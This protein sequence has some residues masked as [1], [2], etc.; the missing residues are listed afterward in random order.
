LGSQQAGTRLSKPSAIV[1]LLQCAPPSLERVVNS[2][3]PLSILETTKMRL[4]LVGSMATA[5]SDWLP[6]ILLRL[7][8]R[9]TARS[10]RSSSGSMENK[11]LIQESSLSG[12]GLYRPGY[13]GA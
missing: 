8:L 6:R 1:A 7:M 3:S 9:G 13:S 5:P 12:Q 2:P 4:A 10:C 11:L